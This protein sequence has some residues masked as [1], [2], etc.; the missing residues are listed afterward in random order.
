MHVATLG[1]SCYTFKFYE[2]RN[3]NIVTCTSHGDMNT[4]MVQQLK[5]WSPFEIVVSSAA[6]NLKMHDEQTE[7]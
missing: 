7:R 5:D 3:H 6:I 4:L 2:P 1:L